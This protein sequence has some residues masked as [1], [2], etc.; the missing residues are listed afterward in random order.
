MIEAP[1]AFQRFRNAVKAVMSVP[2][3][4]LVKAERGKAHKKVGRKVQTNE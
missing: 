4:A 3:T 1:E 2:K